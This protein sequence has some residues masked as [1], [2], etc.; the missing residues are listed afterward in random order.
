MDRRPALRASDSDR[1]RIVDRLRH[2][3]AEGRLLADELEERIGAA[4]SA[5]T[6]G[7]LDRLVRD[8][9]AAAPETRRTPSLV[10]GSLALAA[11]VAVI[12]VAA[13][14]AL[15]RFASYGA[16][17][18]HARPQGRPTVEIGH[19]HQGLSSVAAS[20]ASLF[21]GLCAVLGLCIVLAWLYFHAPEDE[22]PNPGSRSW[23]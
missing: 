9:P 4:F 17:F 1:E 21:V 10:G 12:S 5:R 7:E 14:G 8:L 22:A 16:R 19:V 15:A 23:R 2:A 20:A 13:L 6:Y 11:L 3:A 18:A